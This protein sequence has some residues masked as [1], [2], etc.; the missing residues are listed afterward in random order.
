[1]LQHTPLNCTRLINTLN[2][3][4]IIEETDRVASPLH[5]CSSEGDNTT[6]CMNGNEQKN[7][8]SHQ[9]LAQIPVQGMICLCEVSTASSG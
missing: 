8:K 4:G 3:H 6:T 1:M 5:T 7:D 9:S 2:M